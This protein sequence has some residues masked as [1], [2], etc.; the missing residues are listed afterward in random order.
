[1]SRTITGAENELGLPI[2]LLGA[3]GLFVAAYGNL[4]HTVHK[5]AYRYVELDEDAS[6]AVFAGTRLVDVMS[7]TKRLVLAR[8]LDQQIYDDLDRLF[9]EVNGLSLFRDKTVHRQWGKGPGGPILANL[10]SAKSGASI[11]QTTVDTPDLTTKVQE[12]MLL[13][14]RLLSHLITQE[15]WTQLDSLQLPPDFR[16]LLRCPW[17]EKP[18]PPAT[19]RQLKKGET[20]AARR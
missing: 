4:E 7:A 6:R 17:F 16:A 19:P 8:K 10:V 3:L 11:E 20:P 18:G 14:A 5:I 1:M 13:N 12:C 15:L 9:G 2:S